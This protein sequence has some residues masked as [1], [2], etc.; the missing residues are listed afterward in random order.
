ATNA[1]G[2]N[3]VRYGPMG[4]QVI[5]AGVVLADGRYVPSLLAVGTLDPTTGLLGLLA[6]SE[7]VLAV[8]AHVTLA[9]AP[10]PSDLAVAMVEVADSN[11][12]SLAAALTTV[13]GLFAAELFGSREVELTAKA[14]GRAAP[15]DGDWLILLECRSEADPVAD[16]ERV[17]GDLPA[18]VATNQREGGELWLF[19]EALTESVSRLGIPHKFDARIPHSALNQVRSRVEAAVSDGEVFVWGHLF[20]NREGDPLA[21]LHVNV[22]GSVDDEAVFDV[23]EELGGSIAA[24]HGLG[25]AKR[26]RAQAARSDL[27][28]LWA[29][30]RRLDP[31]GILNPNAVFP[32]GYRG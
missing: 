6:G 20:S 14:I 22:I 12:K 1:G 27:A 4:D 19:R 24:E 23:I 28:E 9:I 8:V 26:H 13:P 30:K 29:L 10:V 16:L 25:T 5:D 31:A 18:V 21:N 2:M 11:L 32:A 3:V 15:V 7:G 17:V